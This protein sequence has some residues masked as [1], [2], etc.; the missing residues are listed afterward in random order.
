MKPYASMKAGAVASVASLPVASAQ[1]AASNVSSSA[2]R[3]IALLGTPLAAGAAVR[4]TSG[5]PP[6]NL[7]HEI[8]GGSGAAYDWGVRNAARS[9]V[10]TRAGSKGAV[11][12]MT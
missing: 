6:L 7:R 8:V 11:D 12:T 3:K 1:G 5:E 10:A 4:L 9:L 2:A